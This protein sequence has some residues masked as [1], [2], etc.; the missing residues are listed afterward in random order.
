MKASR[1][2]C[3][4]MMWIS[5]SATSQKY[6]IGLRSGEWWLWRAFDFSELIAMFDKPGFDV[7]DMVVILL[8]VAIRRW[9]DI[10]MDIVSN[11]TRVGRG[12]LMM[13]NWSPKVCQENPPHHY[14]SNIS[15]NHWC[16]ARWIH[17]FFMPFCYLR[18]C[19][20]FCQLEQFCHSLDIFIFF[21]TS[22]CK[23]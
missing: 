12:I 6:S 22:H 14:S 18:Y 5:H 20:P 10:G 3:T 23:P 16:K 1:S 4:V 13:P 9:V 7:F 15:M 11:N 8:E 2:C 17:E 19:L 21:L